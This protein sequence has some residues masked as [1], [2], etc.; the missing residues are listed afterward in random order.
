MDFFAVHE[1]MGRALEHARGGK[2][3]YALE[4]R[5]VRFLGHSNLRRLLSN[6]R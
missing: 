1:A 3:P 4:I 6:E 5:C 2:G